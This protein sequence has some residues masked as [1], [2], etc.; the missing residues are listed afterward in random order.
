MSGNALIL[1]TDGI[2]KGASVLLSDGHDLSIGS[3]DEVDLVLIDEGVA[4]HHAT[5]RVVG[6][7]LALT[8]LQDPV[9]VFGHP[10][11]A[12][13]S[14]ELRYGGTFVLGATTLQFGGRDAITPRAVRNAETYWLLTHAPLAYVARRGALMPVSAKVGVAALIIVLVAG[15]GWQWMSPLFGAK[16]KSQADNP[17]FRLVRTHVD[18]RT[19]AT[20]Y[21]GYVQSY[22]DLAALAITAR[23]TSRTPVLRVI[24][25]DQLK[26]QLHTFLGRYYRLAE[27]RPGGEAGSFAVAPPPFDGFLQPESWD[28]ARIARLARAEINGLQTLSFV[29]HEVSDGPV[30]VPLESIGMNL[31]RSSHGAWLV[32]QQGGMYF[33]GSRLR[34]GKLMRISECGAEVVRDD[35]GS[36]YEFFTKGAQD[37]N[38]C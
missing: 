26:D 34:I 22:T 14:T 8:A 20:V 15:A 7:R 30:R 12:G 9:T 13:K 29:G 38:R 5:I 31:M 35:D 16:G 1:V 4:A 24:V 25:V 36:V 19:G 27:L 17:A 28:Y 23:G 18:A 2:H 11:H 21:E 10:L 3:G 37:A 6:E 33:A 32:D